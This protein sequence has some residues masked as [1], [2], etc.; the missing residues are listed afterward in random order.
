MQTYFVEDPRPRHEYRNL[1]HGTRGAV[2]AVSLYAQAHALFTE[3]G[4]SSL[5][6]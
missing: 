1:G 5:Y 2:A 6:S 3:H 4:S